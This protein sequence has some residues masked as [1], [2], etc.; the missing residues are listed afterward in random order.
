MAFWFPFSPTTLPHSLFSKEENMVEARVPPRSNLGRSPKHS[1]APESEFHCPTLQLLTP[2]THLLGCPDSRPWSWLELR[3]LPAH[4][5]SNLQQEN[6]HPLPRSYATCQSWIIT[7]R[8]TGEWECASSSSASP[9]GAAVYSFL[10]RA[11]PA[12][13]FTWWL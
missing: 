13:L 3:L 11:L 2:V 4:A 7:A 12:Q 1:T 5:W 9:G 10:T 6:N 8:P